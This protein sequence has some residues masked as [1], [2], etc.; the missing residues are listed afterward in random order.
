MEIECERRITAVEES[1]KSAHHRIDELAQVQNEIHNLA[2]SVNSLAGA[3][4]Q[5]KISQD[6]VA[7]RVREI[8]LKPGRRWDQITLTLIIAVVTA[9][10]GYLLGKIF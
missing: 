7:A 8:E 1:A 3:V 4:S 2:L 9:V 10:A 6:D 5:I